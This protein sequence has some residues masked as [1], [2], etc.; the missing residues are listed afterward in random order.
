[1]LLSQKLLGILKETMACLFLVSGG[2]KSRVVN[3]AM[4]AS[5]IIKGVAL[6]RARLVLGWVTYPDSVFFGHGK[7]Y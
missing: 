3:P 5:L 1:M 6:R 4:V 7:L 2:F